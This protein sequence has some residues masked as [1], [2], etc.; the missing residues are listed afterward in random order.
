MACKCA[1]RR[2]RIKKWFAEFRRQ[3]AVSIAM[4]R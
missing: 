2:E 4:W 3:L 1:E